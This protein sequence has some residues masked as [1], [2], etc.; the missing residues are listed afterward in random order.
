MQTSGLGSAGFGF[1]IT[2]TADIQIVV[3]ATTNL[4]HGPWVPF[5]SLNLTNGAFYFSDPNWTN[6]PAR[7]YRIRSP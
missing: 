6:Y 5:Q 1:N 3:E 7:N 2:G 4:A